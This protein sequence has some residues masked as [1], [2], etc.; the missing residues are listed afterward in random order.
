MIDD[1][2]RLCCSF[3]ELGELLQIA[4][5]SPQ[6]NRVAGLAARQTLPVDWGEHDISLRLSDKNSFDRLQVLFPTLS[7][8]TIDANNSDEINWNNSMEPPG[9]PTFHQILRHI[10]YLN[11][12]KHVRIKNAWFSRWLLPGSENGEGNIH[13]DFFAD[14]PSSLRITC[15]NCAVGDLG[16]SIEE[17]KELL[18]KYQLDQLASWI[19]SGDR[20]HLAS[21]LTESDEQKDR[22]HIVFKNVENFTNLPHVRANKYGEVV[23]YRPAWMSMSKNWQLKKAILEKQERGLREICTNVN[24][25][26]KGSRKLNKIPTPTA[27]PTSTLTMNWTQ[28]PHATSDVNTNTNGNRKRNLPLPAKSKSDTF[29]HDHRQKKYR[30]FE[31]LMQNSQQAYECARRMLENFPEDTE[32]MDWRHKIVM[33]VSRAE[34][35]SIVKYTKYSDWLHEINEHG[36]EATIAGINNDICVAHNLL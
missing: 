31:S 8:F 1:T 12:V 23:L 21:M 5:V 35:A 9:E 17:E 3:M 14:A 18:E 32:R 11:S 19:S 30:M 34:R 15:Q 24:K 22:H 28:T 13:T 36:L 20:V 27:I 7:T 25:K 33:T 29:I 4:E 6:W 2:A 10:M 26:Q 16:V